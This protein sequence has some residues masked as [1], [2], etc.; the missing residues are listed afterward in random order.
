MSDVVCRELFFYAIGAE[1]PRRRH[2][3]G[4]VYAAV[5]R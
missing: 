5:G 2:Y 4:I 3:T 1:L